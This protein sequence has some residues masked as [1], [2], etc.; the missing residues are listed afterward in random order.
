MG[1]AAAPASVEGVVIVWESSEIW[2][3][4]EPVRGLLIL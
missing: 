3:A 1:A 2:P 4:L